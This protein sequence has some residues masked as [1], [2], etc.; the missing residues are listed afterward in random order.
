MLGSGRAVVLAGSSEAK[1]VYVVDLGDGN[2]EESFGVTREATDVTSTGSDG[3]L[4]V[5][6]GGTA[7]DGRAIG[8]VEQWTL[9]GHKDRVV[10]LPGA[11]V[12]LTR[13]AADTVYA[14]VANGDARAAVP[15]RVRALRADRPIPLEADDRDLEQCQVDTHQYLLYTQSN[16]TVAMRDVAS[17]QTVH[18]VVV[19]ESPTCVDGNHRIVAISGN[20]T[21]RAI[22]VLAFPGLIQAGAI[23]ASIN[24]S[25]IYETLDHTLVALDATPRESNLETFSDDQ[26]DGPKRN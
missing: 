4:L 12:S 5:S 15:I 16:G 19:A 3:P 25:A 18:S 6:V 1:A 13:S 7:P 17:G 24:A 14:L 2:V 10:A 20:P 21:A 9:T 11:A 23:P 26:L 22:V 8:A